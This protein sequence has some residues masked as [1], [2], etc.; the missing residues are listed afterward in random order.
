MIEITQ[1]FLQEILHYD[2]DTGLFTW[3]FRRPET[4]NNPNKEEAHK[5]KNIGKIADKNNEY[6]VYVIHINNKTYVSHN[7][8]WMY[9][10]GTWPNGI[11]KH[12]NGNK[13]DNRFINLQ[14]LSPEEKIKKQKNKAKKHHEKEISNRD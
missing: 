14:I 8:V 13:K 9:V 10:Y 12:I 3:K 11:I 6:G 2:Y 4:Y 5:N 7:L 1:E